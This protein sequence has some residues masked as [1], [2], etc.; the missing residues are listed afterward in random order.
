MGDLLGLLPANADGTRR[1][2]AR[3]GRVPRRQHAGQ[4]WQRP[5]GQAVGHARR[6]GASHLGRARPRCRERCVPPDKR[7]LRRGRSCRCGAGRR[8]CRDKDGGRGAGAVRGLWVAR[9]LREGLGR[10]ARSLPLQLLR[11]RAVGA[12][13]R[14]APLR[15]VR[16]VVLGRPLRAGV[17][18]QGWPPSADN[19]GR[20]R[21]LRDRSGSVVAL[22]RSRHRLRRRN[23]QGLGLSVTG[24]GLDFELGAD[25]T[26][27]QS[28]GKATD[29]RRSL[30]APNPAS[31]S[32][33]ISCGPG[34]R[35]GG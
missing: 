4:R 34:W 15:V 32:V 3:A 29:P 35:R 27:T 33:L 8:G 10:A 2:G 19:R 21:P 25:R 26:R 13:H 31:F 5:A 20:A 28:D 14:V 18:P 17:R 7:R 12:V 16:P 9:P 1:L 30:P 24:G 11:P 23:A 22:P 6:H